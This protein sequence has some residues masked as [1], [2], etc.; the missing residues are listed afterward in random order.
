MIGGVGG[1]EDLQRLWFTEERLGIAAHGIGAMWRLLEE[2][3]GWALERE[4]G[5]SRIYRLP[6]SELP[7]RRLGRPTP[8][9]GGC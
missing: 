8:R 3:V 1:G 5:G 7:A 6:G 9:P 2:T 4:Q